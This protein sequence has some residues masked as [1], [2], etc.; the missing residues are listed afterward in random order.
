MHKKIFIAFL[1]CILSTSLGAMSLHDALERGELETL[2]RIILTDPHIDVNAIN[3]KKQTAL[4]LLANTYSNNNFL[5]IITF[6]LDHGAD[7]DLQDVRGNTALIWAAFHDNI[8]TIKKLIEYGANPTLANN[9]KKTALIVAKK[10][11]LNPLTAIQALMEARLV[12]TTPYTFGNRKEG[13]LQVIKRPYIVIK[14]IENNW[15][16]ET[17]IKEHYFHH[18]NNTEFLAK[19]ILCIKILRTLCKQ[20]MVK[21]LI[22]NKHHT[23]ARF[24]FI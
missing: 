7:P 3:S 8:Q 19:P 4:I 14:Y 12:Y 1:A 24:A 11:K 5:E 9:E 13:L 6:L 15:Y 22:D 16:D 10:N 18:I 20:R 21:N 17:I 23:N 2:K